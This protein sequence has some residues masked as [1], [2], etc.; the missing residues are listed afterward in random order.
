[1]KAKLSSFLRPVADST[2]RT[3]PAAADPSRGGKGR[4]DLYAK[5]IKKLVTR[6]RG[7]EDI[8]TYEMG[9]RWP[10]APKLGDEDPA[11]LTVGPIFLRPE[12]EDEVEQL[13]DRWAERLPIHFEVFCVRYDVFLPWFASLASDILGGRVKVDE[14]KLYESIRAMSIMCRHFLPHVVELWDADMPAPL[15]LDIIEER[16]NELEDDDGI[17]EAEPADGPSRPPDLPQ[18][19]IA[20]IHRPGELP[21]S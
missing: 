20:Q 17:D 6:G 16:L 2:S 1:M 3:P 14:Q 12:I 4:A 10:G 21:T 13:G 11:Q 7:P 19:P 8:V 5:I 18:P 15:A 9:A